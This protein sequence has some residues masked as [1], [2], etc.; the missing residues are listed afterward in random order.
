MEKETL[1]QFD[2]FDKNAVI[3]VFGVGGAGNN[4]VNRMIDEGVQG[5]EFW[6]VNTD[7]QVI[8]ASKSKNRIVLGKEITK[9]LGAGADPE[10]GK[11]AC[12]ESEDEI[13]RAIQGTDMVFVAAGMG[14]GTGTGAAPVIAKI[15]K[16]SGALTIGI[17]TKPFRFEGK[18][19]AQNATYGLD[20]LK[21]YVDSLIVI[22]N[23]KLLEEI[24]GTPLKE[25]F[26]E[27]DKI[28]RQGVQTITDLIAVPSLINLDFADVKATMEKKG[29]ALIGIGMAKGENKAEDAAGKAI[30]SPLLEASINGA[31]DAIVNV[32]GGQTM[33]LYDANDAVDLIRQAAGNDV[34]IIFGVAVN[35]NLEDEM[36]V[37]VIA[38]G[39]EESEI[40]TNFFSNNKI[41]KNREKVQ[42]NFKNK[43]LKTSDWNKYQTRKIFN[44]QNTLE[45]RYN[46]N[47]EKKF[48]TSEDLKEIPSFLKKK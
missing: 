26:Q 5:V 35:E 46:T 34:N 45:K 19:R 3:K 44:E 42:E 20:E 27:A 22:S 1:V 23:D 12:L 2:E 28:L 32:T 31:K 39:F 14:G 15:A 43:F 25:A 11:Q 16:D 21:Q 24:G 38:T 41:L 10:K 18:L 17:V 13:K 33:T 4:A 47:F 9:G 29:Y 37:T 30:S 6:V 36:I 8:A 48:N 7:S 40:K